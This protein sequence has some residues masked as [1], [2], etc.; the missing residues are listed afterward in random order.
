[1]KVGDLVRV[2]LKSAPDLFRVGV[3]VKEPKKMY[4]AGNIA[5]VMIDGVVQHIKQE[6]IVTIYKREI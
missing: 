1:V 3:I 5:E 2:R 4:M 6:N